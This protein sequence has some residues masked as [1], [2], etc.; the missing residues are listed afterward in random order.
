MSLVLLGLYSLVLL[1][2]VVP[3]IHVDNFNEQAEHVHDTHSHDHSGHNH[4]HSQN[5]SSD[6]LDLLMALF[7][8]TSNDNIGS[9]HFDNYIAQNNAKVASGQLI[10]LTV[11]VRVL[12][13]I[14][15]PEKEV[16]TRIV[17]PPPLLYESS[18]SSSDPTRGPPT[19]A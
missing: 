10:S 11:I 6:W 4:Q 5:N 1:H 18:F 19:V 8:D 14:N 7:G 2:N 16:L 9:D 17:D 3:H 15:I 13:A 12:T